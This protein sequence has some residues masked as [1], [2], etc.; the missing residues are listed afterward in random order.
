MRGF[1]AVTSAALRGTLVASAK[2]VCA[3]LEALRQQAP[4][5]MHPPCNAQRLAPCAAQKQ[6]QGI[7]G[8][9]ATAMTCKQR[10]GCAPSH[11]VC[12]QRALYDITSATSARM[13]CRRHGT[14]QR[15]CACCSCLRC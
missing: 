14:W 2:G 12:A 15:R 13:S 7:L 9:S 4:L 5:S 8:V 11:A 1:L 10:P 6:S 3:K